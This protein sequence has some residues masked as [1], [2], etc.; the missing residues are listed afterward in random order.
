M[1]YR[2]TFLLCLVACVVGK[3][4]TNEVQLDADGIMRVGAPIT[5]VT[6]G[7]S[8]TAGYS[9][10]SAY[11]AWPAQMQRMLGPEYQVKNYAVSGTTMNQ[12]VNSSFRKTGNY[13]KAKAANPDILVIAHGTNDANPGWWKKWGDQF[14]DDYKS[15]VASFR[16]EGRNPILYSVL[17][18]PVFGTSRVE[19]NKNIEQEVIPRVR[20]VAAEVG[21]EVIDFNTPFVGRNDCFP[22]NVHPSDPTAQRMAE[23]VKSAILPHQKLSAQVKVK[24]GTV[25]NPTTVV[26]EAGSS[27]TLTPSAP[28]KGSWLWSGPNG[29]ASTKRVLKLKKITS[30]GIYTVR[31]QD[32]VGEQSVL[33]FLV[34]VRGQKAGTITT[35]VAVSNGSWQETTTVTARP[36]EDVKFGPSCSAGNDEGTWSWR[37]PNGYFAYGREQMISV[38]TPAKAGQYGVTYTD[39]Q[40]RQT[41]AVYNVKVEGELVCPKLVNHGHNE[42]GWRQAD[43]LYVRPGIPVTFAPHPMNGKWE[44]TGPNGFHSNERHNQ[45]FDFDE[46]MAGKYIATYTNEAGCCEQLVITIIMAKEEDKK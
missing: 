30:G 26:V 28:T 40:G 16:E 42:D 45:I 43:T 3:A 8:I 23:I 38:M 12:H 46:K 32:K 4:Q 19:Q 39:A 24:R 17:A 18:P 5:I 25:I 35:H 33:N 41:S 21:A 10:T 27:A 34:S 1:K 44:W 20:Q 29:F 14:C 15:M 9:N 2:I 13:P 7:N 31:F 37:G 22:D 6:I 11:W 36:G